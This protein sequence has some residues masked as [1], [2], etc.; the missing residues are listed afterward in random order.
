MA[1]NYEIRYAFPVPR[2]RWI[3]HLPLELD[4]DSLGMEH[5]GNC[6]RW[7][8]ECWWA[9]AMVGNYGNTGFYNLV[10][11]CIEHARKTPK[12]LAIT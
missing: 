5:C 3:S 11:K 2:N 8:R 6:R 10:T 4:L 1:Q 12:S 7:Q 9:V